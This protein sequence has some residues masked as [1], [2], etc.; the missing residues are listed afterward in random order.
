MARTPTQQEQ[1]AKSKLTGQE[2]PTAPTAPQQEVG[3]VSMPLQPEE[4]ERVAREG[5]KP[6]P[7]AEKP[8]AEKPPPVKPLP[9]VFTD[10]PEGGKQLPSGDFLI[11]R[12]DR[13]GA[14][15]YIQIKDYQGKDRWIDKNAYIKLADAGGYQQF[16][17]AQ[18]YGIVPDDAIY[19]A[20]EGESWSYTTKAGESAKVEYLVKQAAHFRLQEYITGGGTDKREFDVY[21]WLTDHPEASQVLVDAGYDRGKVSE[22]QGDVADYNQFIN[23]HT[24]IADNKW[25]LTNDLNKVKD[26]DTELYNVLKTEGT[27]AA[28]AYINNYNAQVQKDLNEY[29]DY[30]FAL[31]MVKPYEVIDEQGSPTGNYDLVRLWTSG[32]DRSIA[33]ARNIF[34]KADILAT[35]SYILSINYANVSPEIMFAADKGS[36]LA[37]RI[38]DLQSSNPSLPWTVAMNTLKQQLDKQTYDV[39]Q[40]E[41]QQVLKQNSSE[42]YKLQKQQLLAV[43]KNTPDKLADMFVPFKYT[44][45]NWD[46]MSAVEQTASLAGDV[47]LTILY[48]I[49]IGQMVGLVKQVAIPFTAISKAEKLAKRAGTASIKLQKTEV[50]LQNIIT[51]TRGITPNRTAITGLVTEIDKLRKASMAADRLFLAQ[52]NNLRTVSAGELRYLQKVSGIKDLK[53]AITGANTAAVRLEKAWEK[54][55]EELSFTERRIPQGYYFTFDK[56]ADLYRLYQELYKAQLAYDKAMVRLRGVLKVR[57]SEPPPPEAFG[58]WVIKTPQK[59]TPKPD[60]EVFDAIDGWLAR[61]AEIKAGQGSRFWESKG[62]VATEVKPKGTEVIEL[63]PIELRP[64]T[65]PTPAKTTVPVKA[66][67][68]KTSVFPGIAPKIKTDKKA[69]EVSSIPQEE[70]GRMTPDQLARHYGVPEGIEYRG[71]P[72]AGTGLSY[73]EL[74][75]P[76]I[77]TVTGLRE[78]PEAYTGVSTEPITKTELKAEEATA[79]KAGVKTIPAVPTSEVPPP[80]TPKPPK[81]KLML[82]AIPGVSDDDIKKLK[83]SKAPICWRQGIVWYVI[84]YPYKSKSDIKVLSKPPA[85]AHIVVGIGSAYKTIQALGGNE[86][87][88]T[89]ISMGIFDVKITGVGAKPTIRFVRKKK[90]KGKSKE[91]AIISPRG[92]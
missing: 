88:I 87:L 1:Y 47:G 85:G 22:W 36:N 82:L 78:I 75:Y 9:E 16:E 66:P 43:V 67:R 34:D 23:T 24:Q 33:Q 28:Q 32:N 3:F 14:A 54:I 44:I 56:R 71:K 26:T 5:L 51:Q 41:F 10:I 73:I 90:Y 55:P 31:S 2:T 45:Q 39:E 7:P 38:A 61:S 69:R 49:G 92:R 89:S 11:P 60:D 83:K 18:G 84:Y 65:K 17:L 35:E 27:R 62:A 81:A 70:L 20:G 86:G 63:R 48:A 57:F 29:N 91:P 37:K 40:Q 72:I 25:M 6:P 8:P 21:R 59:P 64:I 77:N 80:L 30:L 19:K 74:T 42:L 46:D 53:G 76:Q 4:I 68:V 50:A 52:I 13:P 12:P 15:T 58:G 79:V